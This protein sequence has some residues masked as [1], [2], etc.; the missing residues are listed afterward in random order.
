MLSRTSVFLLILYVFNLCILQGIST[1]PVIWDLL[2]C[3]NWS[4]LYGYLFTRT[5]LCYLFALQLNR[6]ITV[7][8][9]A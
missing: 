2:R 5:A 4:I 3:Q 8:I 9:L 7:H 6:K 1:E